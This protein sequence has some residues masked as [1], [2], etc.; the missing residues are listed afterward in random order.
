MICM[1]LWKNYLRAPVAR[2]VQ[3]WVSY[4]SCGRSEL[5]S[6]GI[7]RQ[8]WWE[9]VWPTAALNVYRYLSGIQ[10]LRCHAAVSQAAP[11][12]FLIVT[13][14]DHF[15]HD[16]HISQV[17]N[18]ACRKNFWPCQVHRCA[19]PFKMLRMQ[20]PN[21]RKLIIGCF[22]YSQRRKLFSPPSIRT[23][24]STNSLQK[25]RETPS[26]YRD[27]STT[28]SL[29][30]ALPFSSHSGV[31]VRTYANQPLDPKLP[32]QGDSSTHSG[33]FSWPKCLG[34]QQYA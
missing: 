7:A 5:C 33:S 24:T 16:Q 12:F 1:Q 11:S 30:F 20:L 23:T 2:V 21:P 34:I 22:N 17:M 14:L 31:S 4:A 27:N 13:P 19:R 18:T 29:P 25:R 26:L 8:V 3:P 10:E 15:E 6:C 9:Q 32:S 28:V